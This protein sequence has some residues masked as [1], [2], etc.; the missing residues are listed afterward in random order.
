MFAH[1]Q[2]EAATAPGKPLPDSFFDD[3]SARLEAEVQKKEWS[4]RPRTWFILNQI[5]RLDVMEAFIQQGLNDT[6][7]PYKG[8]SSLPETLNFYEGNDF[9][10]WQDSVIGDVLYLEKGQ[11]VRIANGDVLFESRRPKLGIGSQ[12]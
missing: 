2:G 9:L 7:L 12:G 6:S 1:R 5:K 11:H 4:N 8:R 10:K 3:I